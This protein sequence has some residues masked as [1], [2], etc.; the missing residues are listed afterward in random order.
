MPALGLGVYAPEQQQEV[1]LAVESALSLGYR[2]V[3]AASI[4][5]NEVEVG[6][7]LK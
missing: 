3:D 7:A 5:G 6:Q 1:G 4:Y 2:L